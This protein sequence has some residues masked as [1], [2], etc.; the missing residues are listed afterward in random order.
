MQEYSRFAGLYS[1]RFFSSERDEVTDQE[2]QDLKNLPTAKAWSIFERAIVALQEDG[3]RAEAARLF[4]R[5]VKEFPET[6]YADDSLELARELDK[7]IEEDNKY[8]P[9]DN[10]ATLSLDQQIAFHIHNLRD[11][12]AY[13]FMQPGHCL[14]VGQTRLP[15]AAPYNA[16]YAIRDLGEPAVPYLIELLNDRR[17]IRAVGYWR[18]FSPNRTVLRYQDAAIQIINAIREDSPYLRHTTSSYFSIE[19]ERVRTNIISSLRASLEQH[20]TK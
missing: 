12:V 17:P 10:I 4:H 16:A 19:K 9:P 1:A 15:D 5:I 8:R 6:Y 20:K 14:I 18:N 2:K 7:M 13:Q 11:V 3:D